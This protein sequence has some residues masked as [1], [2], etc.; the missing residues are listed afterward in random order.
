[1]AAAVLCQLPEVPLRSTSRSV[2]LSA[3]WPLAL[4]AWAEEPPAVL[5]TAVWNGP[6][7]MSNTGL[8]CLVAADGGLLAAAELN[9]PAEGPNLSLRRHAPDGG[10][11]W[12]AAV[13]DSTGLQLVAWGGLVEDGAGGLVAAFVGRDSSL[14]D[15]AQVLALDNLGRLRW[16]FHLPG[17]PAELSFGRTPAL[18]RGP[19]D[20]L[21]VALADSGAFRLVVL[22]AGTGAPLWERLVL[23]PGGSPQ[24]LAQATCVAWSPTGQQLAVAGPCR[25]PVAGH[26]V[27]VYGAE[28]DFHWQA[29][30]Q[31]DQPTPFG[32]SRIVWTALGDL[33]LAG[34]VESSFGHLH[35]RLWAWSSPGQERWSWHVGPPQWTLMGSGL[36]ALPGGDVVVTGHGSPS[37]TGRQGFATRL[38]SQGQEAWRR[39]IPDPDNG[40][41]NQVDS[42]IDVDGGVLQAGWAGPPLQ[43]W[44][45]K[46]D[47]QGGEAW[48]LPLP[49]WL[50]A[51]VSLGGDR[52]GSLT[53]VAGASGDVLLAQWSLDH[54][55]LSPPR[56][57][58]RYANGSLRLEWDPVAG[59]TTY[60]LRSGVSHRPEEMESVAVTTQLSMD[61]PLPDGP[62]RFWALTALDGDTRGQALRDTPPASPDREDRP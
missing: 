20:R 5:W 24:G 49:G 50:P 12:D 36:H 6:A 32:P 33:V 55:F 62:R 58:I 7:G 51:T 13:S 17:R 38:D 3:L 16:S 35:E 43:G 10:L 25:Q 11:L 23:P 46:T 47:A 8:D 14:V 45:H 48:A 56:L 40:F 2:A 18:A 60:A 21:A 53:Q 1:M 29:L 15:R 37:A 19:E 44:L 31:G 42:A 52:L 27:A 57:G 59:A 28:G 54:P 22:D 9:V 41:L 61:L 26:H 34:T 39:W 4:A 30:R